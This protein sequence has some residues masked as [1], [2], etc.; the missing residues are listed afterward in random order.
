MIMPEVAS[1]ILSA[2]LQIGP[3]LHP[4]DDMPRLTS[5]QL[6]REKVGAHVFAD[7]TFRVD[8]DQDVKGAQV[9][10][11]FC[12]GARKVRESFVVGI[13]DLRR[14]Q[15]TRFHL[16][17]EH[18]QNFSRLILQLRVGDRRLEYV[19]N[20]LNRTPF[21]RKPGSPRL[22]SSATVKA[23]P[24]DSS[25]RLQLSLEVS[26]VGDGLAE[27][28]VATLML[29]E[30]RWEPDSRIRIL[31]PEPIL[32]RT[33][34]CY[35]IELS[36]APTP[37]TVGVK[38]AW[39]SEVGP[40]IPEVQ[41]CSREFGLGRCRI[42]RLTDGSVCVSGMIQNGLTKPVEGVKVTFSLGSRNHILTF[43]E[44]FAPYQM[45][46]FEFCLAECPSFDECSYLVAYKDS[47]G[48]TLGQ[49]DPEPPEV[50]CV[51]TIPLETP[52]KTKH[53]DP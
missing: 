21:P 37:I 22:V 30:E 31:L 41:E 33:Q 48:M 2:L 13:G 29:P 8:G 45:R 7:G 20:D 44:Q 5:W 47:R 42:L 28:V 16:E 53:A 10:L 39:L 27:D 46:R 14:G 49:A 23:I 3:P 15:P 1:L 4:A 34:N 36:G 26:N 32:P 17:A 51:S 11:L 50:S 18:V 35:R 24:G 38:L 19:A 52:E 43:R 25:G 9:N 40:P 12:D 6:T